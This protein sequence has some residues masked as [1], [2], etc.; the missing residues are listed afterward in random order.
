MVFVL[1]VALCYSCVSRTRVVSS[2]LTLFLCRANVVLHWIC[3]W[4]PLNLKIVDVSHVHRINLVAT[5][6]LGHDCT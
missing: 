1:F 3:I 6:P 4:H 5:F 2:H